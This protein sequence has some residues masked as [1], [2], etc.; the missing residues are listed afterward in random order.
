MVFLRSKLLESEAMNE[1]LRRSVS[2]LS[3][4]SPYPASHAPPP[5]HPLGSSPSVSMEAEMT[6]VLRRAKLDIERLKKKERNQRRKRWVLMWNTSN[7]P[8]SC[9]WW[10]QL[11]GKDYYDALSLN[12]S[13][14]RPLSNSKLTTV[15][16]HNKL[17]QQDCTILWIPVNY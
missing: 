2:R 8:I 3:S 6:D 14:S 4:R 15:T 16:R 7:K 9:F 12:F 5:G 1:S 17:S 11:Q 13:T 10:H